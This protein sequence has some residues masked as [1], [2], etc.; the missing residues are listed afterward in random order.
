MVVALQHCTRRTRRDKEESV[1]RLVM[2]QSGKKTSKRGDSRGFAEKTVWRTIAEKMD[3]ERN[4][5]DRRIERCFDEM[6]QKWGEMR[7]R[8]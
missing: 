4:G 1:V 3:R 7:G 8:R 2:G 6:D 5:A